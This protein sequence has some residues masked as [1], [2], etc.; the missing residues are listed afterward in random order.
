MEL[1]SEIT[2]GTA[3]QDCLNYS[4]IAFNPKKDGEERIS[5]FRP[6]ALLNSSLK[7]ISR[8][9]TNKQGPHLQNLVGEHQIS[10]ISGRNIMDGIVAAQK[11]IH[12]A[13]QSNTMGYL[14]KLDIEKAYDMV[15]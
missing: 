1:M 6:T 13:K 15:N 2:A 3:R 10:F 8:V 12:Q 11:V 9:L 4:T 7:I 5:E 14:L